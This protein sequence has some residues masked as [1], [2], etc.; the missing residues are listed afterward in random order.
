[1]LSL[2][3]AVFPPSTFLPE[4]EGLDAPFRAAERSGEAWRSS[5]DKR[6]KWHFP[7]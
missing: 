2:L 6:R 3:A 1:M 4:L 5:G 7:V